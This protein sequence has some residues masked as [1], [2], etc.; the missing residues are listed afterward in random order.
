M[1]N[2]IP[3]DD[4]SIASVSSEEL[5]GEAAPSG[6]A[7]AL[8]DGDSN[9]FWHSKWS[10]T[11]GAYPFSVVFDLGKSYSVT[12]FEYTQRQNACQRQDEG[13]RDLRLQ[14]PHGIR[15]EGCQRRVR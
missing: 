7:A 9:T 6:P 13:L 4:L 15:D 1:A 11:A 2:L 8:L 10:G 14:Q 12:G 3:Q 5:T